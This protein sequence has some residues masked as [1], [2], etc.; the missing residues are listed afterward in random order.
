[1]T[2]RAIMEQK[3]RMNMGGLRDGR[4]WRLWRGR[5]SHS[6][7]RGVMDRRFYGEEF[8]K[9]STVYH[10]Y[11]PLFIKDV[12]SLQQVA[13][14]T[15]RF[16]LNH[17]IRWVH[18][19]GVIV[20][21]NPRDTD[22]SIL[23]DDSSGATIEVVLDDTSKFPKEEKQYWKPPKTSGMDVGTCVQV[24]GELVEKWRIRKLRAL[25]VGMSSFVCSL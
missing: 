12:H 19:V 14:Y 2:G 7:V 17:P 9:Y 5:K 20:A 3:T 22:P 8:W 4:E 16:W 13:P 11:V 1:M 21:L 23:L 6:D 15:A 18:I 24:K 25:K 10:S